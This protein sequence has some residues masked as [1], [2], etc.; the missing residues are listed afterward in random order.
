MLEPPLA[1]QPSPS[2]TTRKQAKGKGKAN[3]GAEPADSR[4]QVE[5][6]STSSGQGGDSSTSSKEATRATTPSV[7]QDE[8][9]EDVT[10]AAVRL[11]CSDIASVKPSSKF[12]ARATSTA[13]SDLQYPTSPIRGDAMDVDG[14]KSLTEWPDVELHGLSE[15]LPLPELKPP[16]HLSKGIFGSKSG[17]PVTR[18]YGQSFLSKKEEKPAGEAVV[19]V[20]SEDEENDRRQEAEVDDMLVVSQTPSAIR[21]S[22][23]VVFFRDT[24]KFRLFNLYSGRTSS[25]WTLLAVSTRR[26]LRF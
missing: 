18:F 22:Q 7:T 5:A 25:L 16:V 9:M 11:S 26:P 1:V 24:L 6:A 21:P 19:V 15:H 2:R 3:A 20:D 17:V 23:C 8:E 10:A 4:S 12:S 13:P 14:E